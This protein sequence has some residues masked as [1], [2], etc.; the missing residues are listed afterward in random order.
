MKNIKSDHMLDSLMSMFRYFSGNTP[1]CLYSE[2]DKSV[3]VLERDCWVDLNDCLL[4]ELKERL[5][6]ENIK[7]V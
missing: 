6:E 2:E 4:K 1:V 7:V 3:R 5:G